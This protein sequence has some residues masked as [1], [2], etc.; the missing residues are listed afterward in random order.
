VKPDELNRVRVFLPLYRKRAVALVKQ[1]T[2]FEHLLFWIFVVTLVASTMYL[3]ARVNQFLLVEI[4]RSGG[5]ITE[6]IVGFS[7]FIN[8]LLASSDPDRD[9]TVLIYSGLLRATPEGTLVPDLA[10]SVEISDDGLSY[11]FVIRED[12]TFHDGIAVTAD[13]VLF[14]ISRAQD[15][16]IKSPKRA[17]WEG[18]LVEK[19]GERTVRFVLSQPYSPFIENTT[20]GILPLHIWNEVSSDQFPFSQFNVEP[21]GSGPYRVARIKR[22]DAGL[23]EF[24]ELIPFDNHALGKPFISLITIRFYA[25]ED[26]LIAA[27]D[28]GEVEALNSISHDRIET[29]IT[30]DATVVDVPLPRVFAVFFNQSEA[31]LFTNA[32]IRRALDIALDKERI[33]DD[34]LG[35]YGTPIYNPIPPGVITQSS[36]SYATLSHQQRVREARDLLSLNDWEL[37]EETGVLER[38]TDDGISRLSFALSTSNTPELKEAA[39]IIQESWEE[40]GASVE[41]RFF[42][43][44]DLSQNV[45]RP[46]RY[47]ALLFGEII[48]RELDLFAFWHSSQRNDPGLNV[49]LYT[50]ITVDKLL[51][52]AREEPDREARL[53]MYESFEEEL[54]SDNPA[55]F[56]YSP[57]FIY[58]IP[59]DVSG[60]ELGTITTSADRFLNVHEWYV[61]T[62]KVW[63][64]FAQ[65]N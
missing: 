63:P 19:V 6:G 60:L 61:E 51:E 65:N 24:Y 7:R 17:N 32:Q 9:L 35:G 64:I 31:P 47:E 30:K 1:F 4:P 44:A 5:S 33:V 20:L 50:N 15:P 38:E 62:D 42:D 11:T 45:I 55:V 57:N 36:P 22:N 3:L 40:I 13:D 34:V 59:D 18:V 10:E 28:K 54:G 39:Q 21:I 2:P 46:R 27:Y 14:T 43:T 58:I 16:T 41:L 8:P 12:A 29:A 56:V 37:N 26:E 23:S 53:E 52:D 25:N 49:A 48:G